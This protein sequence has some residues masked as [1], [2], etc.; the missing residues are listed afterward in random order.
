V[1]LTK[2]LHEEEIVGRGTRGI[3]GGRKTGGIN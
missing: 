3:G 1:F 2:N